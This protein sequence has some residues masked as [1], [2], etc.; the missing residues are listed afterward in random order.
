M[1]IWPDLNECSYI[2]T[3]FVKFLFMLLSLLLLLWYDALSS[4]KHS[5]HNKSILKKEAQKL[6]LPSYIFFIFY[7][8]ANI[9]STAFFLTKKSPLYHFTSKLLQVSKTY[10]NL[11]VFDNI[12]LYICKYD[13]RSTQTIEKDSLWL[14]RINILV[15][16]T[17]LNFI[18][19]DL[20]SYY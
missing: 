19:Y 8:F 16:S 14:L 11:A 2:S 17:H 5:F 18:I 12:S 1:P 9:P 7:F 15:N 10:G 3:D 13:I 4:A 20:F 6:L